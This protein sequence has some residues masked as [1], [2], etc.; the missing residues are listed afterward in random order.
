MGGAAIGVGHVVGNFLAGRF[1]KP[2]RCSG[3]NSH[4]VYR[5]RVCRSIGYFLIPRCFAVDVC[6]LS[7]RRKNLRAGM[8]ARRV[9]PN[10]FGVGRRTEMASSTTT[11]AS[12][13]AEASEGGLPQLDFSTF[14][15]PDFLASGHF[16]CHLSDSIKACFATDR[17]R[18]GR[19]P[20]KRSAT[21]LRWQRN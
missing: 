8:N 1:E 18:I 20:R 16:N 21:T 17:G 3:T 19:T 12:K 2:I 6:C 7:T 10:G 14:G 13:A 15:K 4:D 11:A 9:H 5:Y